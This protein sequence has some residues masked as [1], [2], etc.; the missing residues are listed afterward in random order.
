MFDEC[1][2]CYHF[3]EFLFLNEIEVLLCLFECASTNW[4]CCVRFLSLEEVTI[5]LKDEVNERLLSYTRRSNQDQRFLFEW[6][7]VEWMEVLLSIH[8]DIILEIAES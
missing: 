1:S 8:K 6:R 2:I 5:L 4:S 3:L 7:S